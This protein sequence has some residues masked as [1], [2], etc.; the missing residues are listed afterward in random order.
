MTPTCASPRAPPPW[1][2]KPTV[3]RLELAGFSCPM[4]DMEQSMR[5]MLR[6]EARRR[7]CM[8]LLQKFDCPGRVVDDPRGLVN[9]SSERTFL[10][11][12]M[13]LHG[14]YRECAFR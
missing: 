12:I 13:L 1:R 9:R 14:A 4:P 8:V 10:R 3:E 2:T 6:R 7:R 11:R 5:T